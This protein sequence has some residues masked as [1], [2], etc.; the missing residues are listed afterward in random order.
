VLKL[1]IQR[2]N[3]RPTDLICPT[4]LYTL[5]RSPWRKGINAEQ[6]RVTEQYESSKTGRF[7]QF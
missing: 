4:P 2:H 5:P 3:D 7:H 6:V 1:F